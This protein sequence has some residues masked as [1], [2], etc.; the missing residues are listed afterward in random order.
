MEK[1]IEESVE[2]VKKHHPPHRVGVVR[3]FLLG[4][5][6]FWTG[7]TVIP[8]FVLVFLGL[9]VFG[10]VMETHIASCMPQVTVLHEGEVCAPQVLNASDIEYHSGHRYYSALKEMDPPTA[11]TFRGKHTELCDVEART[12]AKFSYCLPISGR[13][14]T[15][16]FYEELKASGNIPLITF[17]SLVRL[18]AW[19]Y[20]LKH[21]L[22]QKGYHMFFLDIWRVC[23]APNHPLA[24]RLYDPSLPLTKNFAVP[25]VD[26]YQMRKLNNGNWDIQ[27]L[28]GSNG[29]LMP[30]DKVEPFTQ[31]TINGMPFDTVHDPHFFL[32][33]AY[34]SDYMTPK[35][36]TPPSKAELPMEK[37]LEE[38]G[39]VSKRTPPRRVGAV[40]RALLGCRDFW[41][42]VTVIPTF[43]VVLVGLVFF[44][45]AMEAH[46]LACM[47]EFS[48][49]NGHG[50]CTPRVLNVSGIEYHSGHRFY[51]VLK[52][53]GQPKALKFRG[54]H[55]KLCKESQRTKMKYGYCLPISG[56]K[57]T[58]FCTAGDRTDLLTTRSPK[59]V[60]YASVL[61][62][63]LVD[64]Y[65]E[66][67]AS[68]NTPLI[69]FGSLLGAVRNGS[70]IPFT[71]DTDIGYVGRLHDIQPLQKALWNKGYH[72]FFLRIWR[73]CVAPT[74][75]LAAK[76]YDSSLPLT[77]DYAVPYVDLY[78]MKIVKN[79]NWDIQEMDGSNG[80]FLPGDKVEPFSQ[81][82]INGMQFDTVHDPHF[83]LKEAYGPDYMTPQQRTEAPEIQ[84]ATVRNGS[85]IPFTED[86]DIGFV[87]RLNAREVVKEE[88]W[89]KGYHM[90]FKGIW[91]VCVAPTHP[92]AGRLYDPNLP[93]TRNL[94]VPYVDLYRMQ[95]LHNG[96]WDV[97]E[98]KSAVRNGSMIPF[99]EDTDIGFVE[100]LKFK[101]EVVEALRQKGYHMNFAVPYVDLY[102]MKKVND[103]LWDIQELVGSNGRFLPGDKVEPFSQVTI[104][105]MPF[106]TVH[107][108]QFF[109]TEA[110][111]P[112]YMTPKPR[113]K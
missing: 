19:S 83:F 112:N 60:C 16:F 45:F 82:T 55:T 68:G 43:V 9:L 108:P 8:T 88:L 27:E 47:P 2:V 62:M 48:V 14:D 61:H 74:H 49:F 25:Y 12:K 15:P 64:V 33:E 21:E 56:R 17:G 113:S 22:W 32:K 100:R 59:S 39:D 78:R 93:L 109:L 50:V 20:V 5:R 97:E 57:D 3:R 41:T 77:K 28:Q 1:E 75:P 69:T 40:R 67:K 79:G 10:L 29:R 103:S 111:G 63:L 106:D 42:G 11:P 65:E 53:M 13:K 24:S 102:K 46:I 98:L 84:E 85:M 104:N 72:M 36:R 89:N 101:D 30:F 70:M 6:D 107:D 80:R 37:K 38:G 92:L 44:G 99:T 87:E 52:E 31:V 94:G 91:R 105:G 51:S 86:T 18:A 66:L 58:P 35:Q 26:L 34:G 95:D 90:F 54:D 71:E 76:L 81:V 96:N 4:C 23:V 7:V 110:Y 73:V